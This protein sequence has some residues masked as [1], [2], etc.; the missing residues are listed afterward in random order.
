MPTERVARALAL[1]ARLRAAAAAAERERWATEL[2][3]LLALLAPEERQAYV[4]ARRR[5]HPSDDLAGDAA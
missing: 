2:R 5:W 4:E 3:Q 1:H